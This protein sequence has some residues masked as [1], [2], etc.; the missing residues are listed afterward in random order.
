[1]IKFFYGDDPL[2][3]I[4]LWLCG[5]VHSPYRYD[6]VAGNIYGPEAGRARP[7]RPTPADWQDIRFPVYVN[8][9]PGYAGADLSVAQVTV[10][11]DAI[12]VSSYLPDGTIVDQIDIVPGRE[13]I[14]KHSTY[15]LLWENKGK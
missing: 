7:A 5:D 10:D 4:D 1:M 2:C 3:K 12:H 8:D 11:E 9:G 13:F 6:P 15:D 14:V